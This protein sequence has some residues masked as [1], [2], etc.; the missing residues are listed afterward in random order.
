MSSRLRLL[1]VAIVALTAPVW[2][3]TFTA[4]ALAVLVTSGRPVFFSQERVGKDGELFTMRK[5]RSMTTGTNPIVP[6]PARI[7]WIGH[8]LRRTSLDELPQL[9]NVL[10]GTMSLVGPRPLLPQQLPFL[11]ERQMRRHRVLP[12]LTGLAQVSGRN[13]LSWDERFEHD[14]TWTERR[15]TGQYL[16]ILRRTAA[17]VLS[18]TGV[19][20]H[21][22]SDRVLIDLADPTNES[23][24]ADKAAA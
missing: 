12:G 15:T 17:T 5:F 6:D 19:G 2:V 22:P 18:G 1:D 24:R 8:Y 3:P 23:P 10:E 20:G 11:S 13:S 14:I 21:D 9:L 4:A 16:N 7:T